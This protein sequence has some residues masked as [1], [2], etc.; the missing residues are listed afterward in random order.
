MIKN[1]RESRQDIKPN[2][3]PLDR[4]ALCDHVGHTLLLVGEGQVNDVDPRLDFSTSAHA[5]LRGKVLPEG[6]CAR[7][8]LYQIHREACASEG[9][10]RGEET[11]Q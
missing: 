4:W 11:D 6:Q 10:G 8:F 1:S 2:M 5:Q 7:V 3:G 9:R